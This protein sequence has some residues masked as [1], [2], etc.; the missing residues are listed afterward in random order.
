MSKA[1]KSI[2]KYFLICITFL[3]VN[4]AFAQL[5]SEHYLPPMKQVSNN[6]AI[7]EQS[8]YLSTPEVTPFVV[9]VYRGAVFSDQL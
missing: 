5:D 7:V 1:I 4:S 6:E 9:E 2:F 3:I 8:I